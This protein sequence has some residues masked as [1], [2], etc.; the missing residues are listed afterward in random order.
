MEAAPVRPS[1]RR[2]W[3]TFLRNSLVREMTFRGNFLVT[4]LT[5]A[6][7]FAAQVTLFEIIYGSVDQV[8]DWKR[9]E[10]FGF[11]A[12]GLLVNALVETFF[13]PNLSAFSELIR[14]GKLDFALLKPVD[15]QFLVSFEKVEVA[16][17]GQV[18]LAL[19]LLGYSITSLDLWG[20]L[21]LTA[22]GLVRVALYGLLVGC[23]TA[24]FYSLMICLAAASVS[25]GRNTGLYD[26]WFYV[27]VFA[28]YPRD[29]YQ[30]GSPAADALSVAFT[31]VVP[32]LL[33]VTVPARVIV[34]GA[35]EWPFVLGCLLAA[36]GG[37][38]VSRAVFRRSLRGY[39][40]ASS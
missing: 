15:T 21:F 29:I 1:Y 24:F 38:A 4:L 12:T 30:T 23:A 32:I 18:V 35:F 9:P 31:Y 2:V 7:Y 26:F 13:M 3:L 10:Y 22:G 28:R 39:R 11:M 8:G 36:A 25:M 33:V 37:L 27:T 34:K 17:L 16:Q 5:R 19:G 40:S 20:A 6:F 14:T